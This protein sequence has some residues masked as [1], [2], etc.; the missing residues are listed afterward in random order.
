MKGLA[1]DGWIDTGTNGKT[2]G[3][4]DERWT[5]GLTE[6]GMDGKTDGWMDKQWHVL[7]LAKHQYKRRH[8]K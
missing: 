1:M 5:D 2:D 7:T 4:I 6:A 3:W 8:S